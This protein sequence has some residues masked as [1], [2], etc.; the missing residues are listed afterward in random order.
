METMKAIYCTKY[1]STE[2]L[3]LIE[4]DKPVP[5]KNEL[6]VKV[7]ATA[8]NDYDWSLVSGKPFVYR[9]LFGLRKP[10]NPIP[11][12]ELSGVVEDVGSG[13]TLFKVGDEVYGD[14]SNYGFGSF[15]EYIC[16]NE[17]AVMLKP[18]D[19]SFT[20][21]ASIPHASMLAYQAIVEKG[22]IKDGQ[23]VLINGA[24]GGVGNFGL[25]IAKQFDVTVMGVDA[26]DKFAMMKTT[27][28]DECIDYTKEDFTKNGQRY[29]L[30]IDAKTNRSPLAF[31]RSLHKNG[32][33]VTVGGKVGRLLQLLILKFWIRIFTNKRLIIVALKP[34]RDLEYINNLYAAGKI[35]PVIDGPYSFSEIRK[36]IQ[37]F[38]EGK[39]KGKVVIIV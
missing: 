16:I 1:G 24:G 33:Y 7:K 28:F 17:K 4:I 12:M 3:Q 21:A 13:V 14:I 29:N 25:Q 5:T 2:D 22:N 34:N 31:L 23:T 27:G 30:V 38:G 39:H 15:A 8:V 10:K 37:H 18:A 26:G 19:M 11:G 6:L 20:D 35:K 36:A 9:L 32:K